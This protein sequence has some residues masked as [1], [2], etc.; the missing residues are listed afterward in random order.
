MVMPHL[1]HMNILGGSPARKEAGA[2]MLEVLVSIAI[3]AIGLLGLAGLQAR[4]QLSDFEA[5]QR[6]QALLLLQDMADR[7]SVNRSSAASYITANPLG[8]G[9]SPASDC[10]SLSGQQAKD[11][12][13]WSKEIQGATE[14]LDGNKVGTL[15]GAK[16]CV[17][18]P[19]ANQY[20][21][22]IVWQGSTPTVSPA[23]TCG[24]GSFN[25]GGACINDLCRRSASTVVTIGSI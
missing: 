11:S 6:S 20:V 7:I 22:T 12:C 19:A 2:T 13:E 4:L 10:T 3:V 17:S 16:G 5:Y 25:S 15:L 18:S 8:T 14:V 23:I 9:D 1:L 24:S 21:V